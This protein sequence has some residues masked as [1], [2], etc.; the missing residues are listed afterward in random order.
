MFIL[1]VTI[2]IIH[3]V[4]AVRRNR[5]EVEINER[6]MDRIVTAQPYLQ[7]LSH[8]SFSLTSTLINGCSG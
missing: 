8:L 3:P 5:I 2:Y 1:I 4:R 6:E 7:A